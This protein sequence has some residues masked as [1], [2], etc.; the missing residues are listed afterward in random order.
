MDRVLEREIMDNK[1]QVRA[2]AKADFSA[3][4]QLYVDGLMK[5]YPDN[6]DFVVDIGCGPADVLIRLVQANA[7]VLA[8]GIDG[9]AEMIICAKEAVRSAHRAP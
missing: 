4:N 3:S 9:S 6:L 5:D 7:G 8:T 1:S 2:Y